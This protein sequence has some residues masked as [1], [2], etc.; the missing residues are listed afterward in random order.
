MS[1]T[2]TPATTANPT[3]TFVTGNPNKLR[4][5][6]SMAPDG[7]HFQSAKLDLEEIQDLEV[8]TIVEHK[9]R[10][11]YAAVSTPV[12]V[13]DVAA[14]LESLNGLPGPFVKFFEQQL[15]RGALYKL[16]KVA[17]DHVTIRC[18]V[19]YYD[20]KNFLYGEGVLQGTITAPRGE[21]G[22]GFDCVVVPDNQPDSAKR[23]VAEMSADEK[24]AISHRG[25]AFRDLLQ[26]LA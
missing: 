13:E 14:S 23:T 24:N 15:G 19:G 3:I 7:L 10:Q 22:F 16:S 25:Q 5:L 18:V 6:T 4:E 26:Q 21:N 11:A 1:N 20:G 12:I 17:D 8:R 9:L 2:Q